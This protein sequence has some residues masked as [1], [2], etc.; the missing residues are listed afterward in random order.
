MT[1]SKKKENIDFGIDSRYK[2]KKERSRD[3]LALMEARL[4]RMKEIRP[5]EVI[6]AKLLQLKL[7]MEEFLS[8]PLEKESNY[9]TDFLTNY[10]DT[11][12]DKRNKFAE[13]IGISAVKLSQV[14]NNHREPQ[15]EFMLRLMVHSE[16][17]Y[18]NICPFGNENWYK[19]YF[20]EKVYETMIRQPEW[21]PNVAIHVK[22]SNLTIKIDGR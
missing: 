7:K 11:I 9:F 8:K 18:E 10:I 12:Y 1:N 20:H 17:V 3:G 4:K 16:K 13:D 6:K 15:D 14:L 21:K 19:I 5:H 2:N 22:T